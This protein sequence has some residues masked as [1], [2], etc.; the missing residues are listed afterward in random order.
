M[1]TAASRSFQRELKTLTIMIK[2]YCHHHHE[3]GDDDAGLCP[4][5]K[6]LQSYALQRIEKCPLRTRRQARDD[7]KGLQN[8]P[9]ASNP[10]GSSAEKPPC[11]KCPVHCYRPELREQIRL[12]M[13]WA[14]PRML[15]RHPLLAWFHLLAGWRYDKR[16]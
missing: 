15:W 6:T 5:C 7:R 8:Q 2:H 16:L 10:P 3:G 13:R 14:G 12:V 11:N 9:T 4:E 1:T